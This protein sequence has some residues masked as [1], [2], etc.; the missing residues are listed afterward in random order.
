M[1]RVVALMHLRSVSI[2]WQ[3][4]EQSFRVCNSRG[5][6]TRSEMHCHSQLSLLSL[7]FPPYARREEWSGIS[8]LGN[9]RGC[10][11]RVGHVMWEKWWCS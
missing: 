1:R 10:G 7:G 8:T 3:S 9:A 11:E 4:W 6:S 2:Y 5:L